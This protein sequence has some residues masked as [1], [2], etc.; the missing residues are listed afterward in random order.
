MYSTI[1]NQ[2][3]A[4]AYP[5]PRNE[6]LKLLTLK[7]IFVSLFVLLI[8]A[9]MLAQDTIWNQIRAD[10][11]LHI[12]MPGTLMA[13]DTLVEQNGQRTHLKVWRTIIGENSLVLTITPEETHINA[14][15]PESLKE[16]FTGVKEG[17][18]N[19]IAKRGL[20]CTYV[21]TIINNINCVKALAYSTYIKGPVMYYYIFLVN[22]KLYSLILSIPKENYLKR[23]DIDKLV[24]SIHFNQ[25]G[26][27]EQQFAS[28][29]ESTG[30]RVGYLIGYVIAFLIIVGVVIALVYFITHKK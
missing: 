16:A 18:R 13:M 8:P 29:A 1:L 10:E 17:I 2:K 11:D 7:K 22:D 23:K 12:A 21:D 14:D 19:S 4:L 9:F 25:T 27:K 20:T 28:K 15:N 30:Y 6:L 5:I 24:N 26:I 3:V